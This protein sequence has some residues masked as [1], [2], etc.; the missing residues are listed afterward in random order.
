MVG[1]KHVL[2]FVSAI[3][4]SFLGIQ[5]F[6][7]ANLIAG[8][9]AT[10]PTAYTPA[11]GYNRAIVVAV[12][13]DKNGTTVGS[14][15]AMTYGGQAMTRV[16]SLSSANRIVGEIWYIAE[17]GISAARSACN[18]NFSIT[19]T[20]GSPT[21]VAFIAM[22]LEN[23]NQTTPVGTPAGQNANGTSL[24]TS[25]ITATAN[26]LV[27]V[28]ST[29]DVNTTHSI[30]SSF[31]EQAE[32]Q[33]NTTMVLAAST[34]Q[35]A[36]A[37][38][39]NPTS[40][41]GATGNMVVGGVAFQGV[42]ATTAPVTYYSR[43]TGAWDSNTTWS[44]TASGTQAALPTG[45]W[46]RRVDNVVINA[47]H[48]V[49]VNAIDDNK[50]C[51]TQPNTVAANVGNNWPGSNL[52]MFYQTGDVI[53]RGT[54]TVTGIEIMF[55]G[56]THLVTGG[57]LT[58]TSTLV[59]TGN[60]EVDAS[61]TLTTADDLCLVGNSTTVI[62]TNSI[63]N[64][65]LIISYPQ[66]TLCGSGSQ[67]LVNG[68]GS[69]VSYF[70]GATVT[71]I[72]NSF[73]VTCSGVGCTGFPVTGT[74]TFISGYT[75]PGGVGDATRN[76][77]W[78]KADDLNQANNSSITSW[79]DASGNGFNA[80]AQTPVSTANQPH[81]ITNSVNSLP[82]VQFR[83]TDWLVVGNISAL[84]FVPGTN[85]WSYFVTYNVAAGAN[86]TF[87]SKA[88]QNSVTRSYQ[89]TFD[90]NAFTS[91]IGGDQTV[92]SFNSSGA[93]TVS[94]H[95]N[96]TSTRASFSNENTNIVA[97]DPISTGSVPGTDVMVGA[98]RDLSASDAGF[99]I[100]GNIGEMAVY[101]F[102]VSAM[103]RLVVTNYLAAKY[104]IA[105]AANDLY[106]MDNAGNGNFDYD[107][108][109]IGQHTDGSAHT[110]ARGSGIVRMWSPNNLSN[111]EYLFWGRD[112]GTLVSSTTS[113]VDGT[114]IKERMSRT[115]R[116][117]ETG[118]VGTTNISFNV[119]S[120]TGTFV[121]SNLRLL[122]D[123]NGNGFADNDVTPVIGTFSSGIV[124]FSGVNLQN[125]DR[126]TLGNTDNTA[127]LP[128][129][130]SSF[131]AFPEKGNV[132]LEWTTQVEI[133]NDHFTIERS[134]DGSNWNPILVVPGAGNSKDVLHYSAVDENAL[135]GVS[136]YRLRQTDFDGQSET[137][138]VVKVNLLG[139]D[140]LVVYP[141]PST[142][143]FQ[144]KALFAF[145]AQE[146]RMLDVMG[147]TVPTSMEVHGSTITL[148][149]T[150]LSAGIYFVQVATPTGKKTV[151]VLKN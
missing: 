111:G 133:D 35:F 105:L 115:W 36:S 37:T 128:I 31:T 101:N 124:T 4:L 143:K 40:T 32:V 114:I 87:F 84:N 92:G 59:N 99:I 86:G 112:A 53:I 8:S 144:V 135:V 150:H 62:N 74:G 142:G 57:T 46:P 54:L 106:L 14:V 121:G 15:S 126:F 140:R 3:L 93:W 56:Y 38:T 64:D 85:S 28:I 9:V 107:V 71:Q 109:G 78:L 50:I 79:P 123:R 45:V 18:Y 33:V 29:S 61:S 25:N 134:V 95:T 113:G 51:G 147:R 7:Q 127:P 151:R 42:A 47:G 98:R 69:Q 132:V 75:G 116:V 39:T 27:F 48:N 137:S 130:L 138:E 76:K 129:T 70:N 34:R 81:F 30:N 26:S 96:N 122:I 120:F 89:Y 58:T 90:T 149:A 118:D 6:A 68:S 100:T 44:L 108:A 55:G 21:N 145:D 94:S 20:A 23:V 83:G 73:S 12:A 125:G 82:S 72:C 91:F 119:S 66:A 17:A 102:E 13:D 146:I 49:T 67:Q 5:A 88:T 63:S 24:A 148:D 60:M 141:N 19:W 41:F 104:G 103:Q 2:A 80:S 52:D 65:D 136:Y 43:Q 110:D 77:L 11:Q 117:S 139:D 10:S 1:K 22:T 16:G 97:T 131:A